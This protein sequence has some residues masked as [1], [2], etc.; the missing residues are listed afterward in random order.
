MNVLLSQVVLYGS[1]RLCSN[2][3]AHLPNSS[4]QTITGTPDKNTHDG[5]GV[6]SEVNESVVWK[7]Y[8]TG[9]A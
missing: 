8:R 2:S 5:K 4:R 3:S 6:S 1:E 9:V 7:A